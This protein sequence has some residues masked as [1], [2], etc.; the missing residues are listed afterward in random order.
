MH[1]CM[2]KIQLAFSG[3][4]SGTCQAAVPP[5]SG[6]RGAGRPLPPGGRSRRAAVSGTRARP[7][8][9]GAGTVICEG[10]TWLGTLLQHSPKGKITHV[11]L[12]G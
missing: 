12:E 5:A 8:I 9:H 11:C 4:H 7:L 1:H 6:S 2:S 3:C 10:L